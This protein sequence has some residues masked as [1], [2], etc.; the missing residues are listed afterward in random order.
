MVSCLTQRVGAMQ[1]A[2]K[3]TTGT[4]S[5]IRDFPSLCPTLVGFDDRSTRLGL[6][7]ML[8]ARFNVVH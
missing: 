8:A 2:V 4:P 7:E 6:A 5:W 1:P 3:S